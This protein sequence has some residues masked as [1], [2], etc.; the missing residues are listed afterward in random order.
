MWSEQIKSLDFDE[1][2]HSLGLSVVLHVKGDHLTHESHEIL[3]ISI[4]PL[5]RALILASVEFCSDLCSQVA[6]V[7][8]ERKTVS[9]WIYVRIVID[10]GSSESGEGKVM[11]R[12]FSERQI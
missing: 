1:K 4:F 11:M 2:I 9:Q 6:D 12:A 8:R 10:V 5:L 3:N 7:L